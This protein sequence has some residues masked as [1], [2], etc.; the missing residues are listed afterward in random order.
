VRLND[1]GHGQFQFRFGLCTANHPR[2]LKHVGQLKKSRVTQQC[3]GRT[4][5]A[6]RKSFHRITLNHVTEQMLTVGWHK[7]RY[8]E[9]ALLHLLQ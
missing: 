4:R 7:M 8:V 2:V 5:R 9:H 1:F 3:A 6:Y